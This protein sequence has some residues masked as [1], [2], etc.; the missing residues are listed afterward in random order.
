MIVDIAPWIGAFG[1]LLACKGAS[2]R[3]TWWK[4]EAPEMNDNRIVAENHQ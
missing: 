1:K 2:L 3:K 4:L